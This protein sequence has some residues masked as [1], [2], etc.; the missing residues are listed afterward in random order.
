M[1]C[2]VNVVKMCILPNPWS[3]LKYNNK[4]TYLLLNP[5]KVVLVTK[6]NPSEKR[7]SER[8]LL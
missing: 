4:Y 3:I 1:L 8:L 7:K 5:F 2:V 6:P